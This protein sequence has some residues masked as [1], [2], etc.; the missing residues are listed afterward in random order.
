MIDLNDLDL[1]AAAERGYEFEL[2]HPGTQAPLGMFVTVQGEDS[3]TYQAELR[4]MQQR[5]LTGR[6]APRTVEQIDEQALDLLVL[7]TIGWRG[8]QRD[9]SELPCTPENVRAV[10]RKFRWVR[11]QVD[12][13]VGDRANFLPALPAG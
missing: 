12:A 1:S 11:E 4:A 10:Y 9:G 5:R 7:A 8:I 3:D 6:Q 2:R 13:A